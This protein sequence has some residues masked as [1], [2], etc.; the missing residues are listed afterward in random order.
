MHIFVSGTIT[1]D[2]A[3]ADDNAKR[4]DERNKGVIFKKSASF[5]DCIS[6][7]NNTQI[8]DA[9]YLDVVIPMC[10]LIE[11]SDNYSK[12]SGS[13]WQYLRD[14]PYDNIVHSESFKFKINMKGKT[15]A[16]GNAKN[17]ELLILNWSE[18][19]VISYAAGETKF[20]ITD[21]EHYVPVVTFLTQDN[22]K[23]LEQL[24]PGFQA[25]NK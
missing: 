21:T 7:I 4:L 22:E 13:L 25:T 24:R 1:T 20:A 9:K 3:E 5:T 2:G 12:T 14:D 8:D 11:L 10:N 23:L 19:C 18:N 15:P 6:E 17:V 16:A